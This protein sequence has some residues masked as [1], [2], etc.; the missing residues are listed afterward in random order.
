MMRPTKR[1]DADTFQIQKRLPTSIAEKALGEPFFLRFPASGADQDITV[2]GR[3][4]RIIK[5]P[6]KTR[7]P[8]DEAPKTGWLSRCTRNCRPL[9]S[10]PIVTSDGR[11]EVSCVRSVGPR[12]EAAGP[13]PNTGFITAGGHCR[14]RE[15]ISL[16]QKKLSF[17][18]LLEKGTSTRTQLA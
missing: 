13:A 9:A 14:G 10:V 2:A 17:L 11:I 6:L 5:I 1:T 12:S 3:C 18:R 7:D 8:A 16:L 15:I 4:K